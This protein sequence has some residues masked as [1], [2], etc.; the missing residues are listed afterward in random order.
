MAAIYQADVW[1]DDCADAIRERIQADGKAP[2]DPSDESTYDS[3]EYP[4]Y[5]PDDESEF[6]WHCAAGP[7]CLN[8]IKLPSGR[9]VGQ[10]FSSLTS[11]GYE[12]VREAA[13]EDN[14]EVV[15][16]WVKHFESEGYDFELTKCPHC[17]GY[18]DAS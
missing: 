6:P 12:R 16:L 9:K 1:C 4:K 11:E 18:M 14:G 15:R 5:A 10:L 17:G 2:A 3:D 7:N 13:L 8:A